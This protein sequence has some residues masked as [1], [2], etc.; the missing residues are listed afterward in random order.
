MAAWGCPDAGGSGRPV[1]NHV[2]GRAQ[3]DLRHRSEAVW[4]EVRVAVRH[5]ITA[6]PGTGLGAPSVFSMITDPRVQGQA[7]DR[8]V[9]A[10]A[11]VD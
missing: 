5:R 11:R 1:Q 4:G 3:S 6:S 10:G 9:L 8:K 2:H 7:S